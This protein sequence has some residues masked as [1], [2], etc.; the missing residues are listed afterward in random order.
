ML[1]QG[2]KA[3]GSG[4]V[5][6]STRQALLAV[7]VVRAIELGAAAPQDFSDEANRHQR[8]TQ[9]FRVLDDLGEITSCNRGPRRTERDLDTAPDYRL[10]VMEGPV[11]PN[12]FLTKKIPHG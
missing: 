5:P 12:R 2:S 10:V 1:S 11:G 3:P 7:L 8:V 9:I 4:G 6:S